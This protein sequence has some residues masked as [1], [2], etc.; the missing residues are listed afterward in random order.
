MDV[1]IVARGVVTCQETQ[2]WQ[3]LLDSFHKFGVPQKFN[4]GRVPQARGDGPGIEN[5]WWCT[6][7]CILSP[8]DSAT[9]FS[10]SEQFPNANPTVSASAARLSDNAITSVSCWRP[11]AVIKFVYCGLCF[12]LFSFWWRRGY[13]EHATDME[14]WI[15]DRTYPKVVVMRCRVVVSTGVPSIARESF[16]VSKDCLLDVISQRLSSALNVNDRFLQPKA[17]ELFA[18]ALSIL[19]SEYAAWT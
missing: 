12:S 11:L 2:I 14:I 13:Q 10:H 7:D 4:A 17:L 16:N 6:A 1:Q 8:S 5:L 3:P 18:F 15:S 19:Q 9:L